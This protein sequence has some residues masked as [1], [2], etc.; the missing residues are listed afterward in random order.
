MKKKLENEIVP[1]KEVHERLFE[2]KKQKINEQAG[3]TI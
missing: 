3:N 1:E 2:P